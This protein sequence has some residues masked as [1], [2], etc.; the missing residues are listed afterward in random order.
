M[1]VILIIFISFLQLVL[2]YNNKDRIIQEDSVFTGVHLGD[3]PVPSFLKV[4]K[5]TQCFAGNIMF[6]LACQEM[7]HVSEF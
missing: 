3:F 1:M 6:A 7:F 5:S 4:D 2:C